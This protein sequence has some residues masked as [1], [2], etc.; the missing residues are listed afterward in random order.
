M[1]QLKIRIDE[2]KS[3]N[4]NV[5]QPEGLAFLGCFLV[6]NLA[7]SNSNYTASARKAVVTTDAPLRNHKESATQNLMS[8]RISSSMR[9]GVFFFFFN[10]AK[11]DCTF[12]GCASRLQSVGSI[13][14]DRNDK[15]EVK[16]CG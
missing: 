16:S 10:T 8:C 7:Q 3:Y 15:E 2:R 14:G 4:C 6:E 9:L 12:L 13:L 5:K 11:T 1:M